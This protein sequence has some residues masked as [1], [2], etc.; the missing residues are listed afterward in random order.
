MPAGLSRAETNRYWRWRAATF[1]AP[2]RRHGRHYPRARS[3]TRAGS[4]P[5]LKCRREV[6]WS[7]AL[8]TSL[9]FCDFCGG[10]GPIELFD[11]FSKSVRHT[12]PHHIVV[13]GPELVPDPGLNFGIQSALL[14]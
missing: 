14:L 2:G 8:L 6:S 5:K 12:L 1:P 9:F 11:E 13:H 10:L 7:E 4:G 3:R